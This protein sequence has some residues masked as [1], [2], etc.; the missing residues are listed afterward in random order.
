MNLAK[1]LLRLPVLAFFKIALEKFSGGM[2]PR[3]W[4]GIRSR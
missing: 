1:H 4:I 2:G 3:L